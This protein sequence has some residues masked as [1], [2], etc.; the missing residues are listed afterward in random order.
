[1]MIE[2]SAQGAP[3]QESS[4]I[5]RIQSE[6]EQAAL[7]YVSWDTEGGTRATM[8]LLRAPVVLQVEKNGNWKSPKPS[9][10]KKLS[11]KAFRYLL[12]KP[13]ITWD[14]ECDIDRMTMRFSG[15]NA[16]DTRLFFPFDARAAATTVFPAAWNEDGSFSLPILLCA[17]DFGQILVSSPDQAALK[18][19]IEGSRAD[20]TVDVIIDLALSGENKPLTLKFEP[21][22]LPIPKG[23]TNEALWRDIRRG[24][25]NILQPSA[26]WG[27]QTRSFSAPPGILSNNVISDP[28]SCLIH[29]YADQA[30][31]TPN[32][33]PEISLA[34]HV[35]RTVD[36]W[37]LHKTRPT[38]EVVAYWDYG[39]ML[40][41]NASPLIAA[42]DYVE[43]TT[44][45]D[46]LR[47]R[48]ERLEFIADY[49]AKRDTDGDGL[50][51]CTHSGNYGSLVDPARS[52]S[53]YDT[54]N[55][56]FK[57]AYSNE[58]TYRAWRCLA[59]LEKK[60]ERKEQQAHYTQL[61]DRLKAVF[62]STLF[63]PATGWIAWWKSE[64]GE[65]HNLA[66]PM[67]NALAV[68]YGLV[69][70]QAAREIL[71][72][73]W[74]KIEAVGFTRFEIGVPVTLVPVRKG[75]YLQPKPGKPAA[76]ICG[77]PEREDGADTFGKYLNG[78]CCVSDA[79]HFM[80][81]LYI[82]DEKEKGDR[83]LNS[84]LDRQKRGVFPNGGAFQNGV[85]DTYP[86]GAE[87]F[88]WEGNT[89]GYEGHLTYSFSFL[90]AA[91]LREPVM[92][93]RLLRP[94]L[95]KEP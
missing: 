85:I 69:E 2:L 14:I 73:L 77:A 19:R 68:E 31:F 79:V 55:A 81:A 92:R 6:S 52:A 72:R 22:W 61:A 46:W 62:F 95:L 37:I 18:G 59:D 90:Q 30:F 28:V 83:I 21:A 88:D 35:R 70:K 34:A 44:D 11:E 86:K 66:S 16:A 23:F 87:F 74:E 54:I 27:D 58:L 8:N 89:C 65:M 64:D 76:T 78:G 4:S 93:A 17:P 15:E 36:Y 10:K 41:A 94:V 47:Q 25:F 48:I 39:D 71:L 60:L 49:L 43:S 9:Q 26:R 5:L 12:H 13:E 82:V 32:V 80:T 7:S 53:A 56:G 42:W 3:N 33:T 20:H 1:M 67:I 40:D 84:M 24:W 57:D 50:V 51:E 45:L 91:L 38:G 63:D 29:L 75:D